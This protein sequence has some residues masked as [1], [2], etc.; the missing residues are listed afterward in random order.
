MVNYFPNMPKTGRDNF[1]PAIAL[2]AQFL[3]LYEKRG[4]YD[5]SCLYV[6]DTQ[7]QRITSLT[8]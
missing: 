1:S 6:S 3:G 2:Y 7:G 8:T 4:R 5:I